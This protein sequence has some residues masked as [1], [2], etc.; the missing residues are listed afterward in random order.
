MREFH[1]DERAGPL[2]VLIAEDQAIIRL[3]L[4]GVL[5]QHGLVVCAEARDGEE[6]VELARTSRPDVALLDM[7]MPKLDGI[8]AAR[9]I[10]AERPIPMVMVTAH[11]DRPLVEKAISAGAFAYLSKPFR[12]ACASRRARTEDQIVCRSSPKAARQT[13]PKANAARGQDSSSSDPSVSFHFKQ[14]SDYG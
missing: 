12:A 4:R 6:A 11:A 2:R 5:E 9:R 14:K 13:A 10:Y 7:R 1:V 8:E 3:D